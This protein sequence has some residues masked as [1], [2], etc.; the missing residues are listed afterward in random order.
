MTKTEL[1]LSDS[2]RKRIIADKYA[3]K[4]QDFL[5]VI[6]DGALAGIAEIIA[7]AIVEYAHHIDS[8]QLRKD[9]PVE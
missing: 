8:D 3:A 6:D 5:I 9:G 7:D 1:A 4:V 2:D